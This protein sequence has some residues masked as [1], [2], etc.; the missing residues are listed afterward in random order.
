VLRGVIGKPLTVHVSPKWIELIVY[1]SS[2]EHARESLESRGYKVL[3]AYYAS[4]SHDHKSEPLWV[5]ARRYLAMM[6]GQRFWEAHSVGEELWHRAGVEGRLLAIIAGALAKAQEGFK[7]SALA[8]LEKA[9]RIAQ[10]AGLEDLIDWACL[11]HAVGKVYDGVEV[12]PGKCAVSLIERT[13]SSG[14]P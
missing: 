9:R 4:L 14:N 11:R 12:D 13:L 10:D 3:E 2:L 5:L 7:G 1:G 8:I 6:R